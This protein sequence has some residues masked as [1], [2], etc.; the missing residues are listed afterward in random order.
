MIEEAVQ[1][2]PAAD[3]VEASDQE[4]H[5]DILGREE[6]TIQA[7]AH[8]AFQDNLGMD[9]LGVPRH[10][11]QNADLAGVE[12][13]HKDMVSVEGT[14]EADHVLPVGRKVVVR[15]TAVEVAEALKVDRLVERSNTA[16]S[17]MTRELF[18]NI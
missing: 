11:D 17:L 1:D 14:E 7:E 16:I 13:P 6:G 18:T 9:S 8:T 12:I 15:E 4:G 5:A 3:E 2:T 10:M